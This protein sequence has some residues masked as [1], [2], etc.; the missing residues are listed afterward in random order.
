MSTNM[1]EYNTCML[2]PYDTPS[3]HPLPQALLFFR[4]FVG[5]G[6]A[7]APVAYAL[8]SEFVPSHGRGFALVAIE[9]FWTIGTVAE[10]GL[11]WAMINDHGW[12]PLLAISATPLG[13]QTAL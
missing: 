7:G 9:G 10:A 8:L 12:R 4:T 1:H 2:R 11:A 13:K 3:L 6:L 5:V